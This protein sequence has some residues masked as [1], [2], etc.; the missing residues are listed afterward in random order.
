MRSG[1]FKVAYKTIRESKWQSSLTMFGIVV[2]IVSVVTIV[3]LGQGIK[4]QI[5]GEIK[6]VGK[7]VN[8]ITSF[9]FDYF[10]HILS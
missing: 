8:S 5:V 2:G 10:Y 3:S 6:S 7:N 1:N 4:R 9:L